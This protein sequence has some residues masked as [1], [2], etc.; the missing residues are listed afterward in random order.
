MTDEA[1]GTLDG[2]L[3]C[4]SFPQGSV[5]YFAEQRGS[6]RLPAKNELDLRAEWRRKIQQGE[7]GLMLD[8]FNVTNQG[9]A[10][11]VEDRT[12]PNLGEPQTFNSPRNFRLGLRYQF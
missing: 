6:R 8:V 1:D 7:L 4:H 11:E 10:T 2:A 12:G 3:D 9:R 5:R